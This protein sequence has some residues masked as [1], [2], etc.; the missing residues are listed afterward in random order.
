MRRCSWSND[1]TTERAEYFFS[2]RLAKRFYIHKTTVFVFFSSQ[3]Q[4][5]RIHVVINAVKGSGSGPVAFEA[6]EKIA[7]G[8]VVHQNKQAISLDSYTDIGLEKQ[9]ACRDLLLISLF[10][11]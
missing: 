5:R 3:G 11:P 6:V 2:S 8:A 7:V 1:R 9:V 10:S 4:S